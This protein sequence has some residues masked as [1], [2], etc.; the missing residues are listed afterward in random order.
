MMAD[1]WDI[2]QGRELHE[3]LCLKGDGQIGFS[4]LTLV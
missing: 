4:V 2:G 3:I 1:L